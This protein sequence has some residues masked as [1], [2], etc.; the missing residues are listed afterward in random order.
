MKNVFISFWHVLLREACGVMIV[1]LHGHLPF[2]SFG[3]LEAKFGAAWVDEMCA[4][5]TRYEAQ[6][7]AAFPENDDD[8]DWMKE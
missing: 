7:E 3:L 1:I 2:F 5:I 4:T 6:I 8:E